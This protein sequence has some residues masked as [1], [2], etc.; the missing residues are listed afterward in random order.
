MAYPIKGKSE[1]NHQPKKDWTQKILHSH[2]FWI[3]MFIVISFTIITII[4]AFT[5]GSF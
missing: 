2:W 4:D 1:P 5:S 3:Y